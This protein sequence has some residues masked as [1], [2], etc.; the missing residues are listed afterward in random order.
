MTQVNLDSQ[1]K[2]SIRSTAES[3]WQGEA[4]EELKN[5][6]RLPC[7]NRD[8]DSN[9]ETNGYLLTACR[10]A[11]DWGRK[12][13]FDGTF[14]V[15]S[16]SGR[17]PVLFFDIPAT[18]AVKTDSVYFYGHFD[19]QPEGEGWSN[20]RQAFEPSVEGE[21]LYGRGAADD[22]YNYYAALTAVLALRKAG[23][24]HARIV[25][26]YET[27]EE[28]GSRDFEYWMQQCR[29]RFGKVGLVVVMD[30]G[31]PDYE[32]LWATVSFRGAAVLT[33]G[34]RVAEHGMHSGLASGIVPSSFMIARALLDRIENSQTGEMP[35]KALNAPIPEE[36]QA[37]MRLF[38]QTLGEQVFADFPW[39][40]G[41]QPRSDDPYEAVVMNTWKPQLSVTGADGI[42]SVS[43]A[44]NVLRANTDL[45]LS[46][47]LP[48]SVDAKTALEWL[49]D[50]LTRDPLFGCQVTVTNAHGETGWNAPKEAPWLLQAMNE[51]GADLFGT[52][53]VSCGC[54]G[55]IGILPLFD[56]FFGSPQYLLTGVLGAESNA[57]GPNEMLRL[58]YVTKLT[59]AVA[60]VVA[61]V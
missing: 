31:G 8:F 10:R 17:T 4:L 3:F 43:T 23:V 51:A 11:A 7:K 36:R 28:C 40:C 58:D 16:E 47:R 37:Q 50:T 13:F 22:G 24:T 57:H 33:L 21:R 32:R 15:L 1:A 48:P 39:A 44:G 25:G 60:Q 26:L 6:V 52:V 30:C 42:P 53:P 34:V 12:H 49:T 41:T 45:K 61:A 14:E 2:Q 27:D 18:D 29:D 59:C 5:F 9:W 56:Q 19:K 46:V 20:G 38:A 54:G 35:A 55:S